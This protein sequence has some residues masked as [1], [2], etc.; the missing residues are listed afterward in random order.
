MLIR[1]GL[2]LGGLGSCFI[3][4]KN[5][6]ENR[7]VSNL[8]LLGMPPIGDFKLETVNVILMIKNDCSTGF[9]SVMR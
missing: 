4:N 9:H 1:N 8:E 5:E 2:A 7:H 6:L 3:N